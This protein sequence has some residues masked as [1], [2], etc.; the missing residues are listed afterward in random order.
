MAG[1]VKIIS[2]ADWHQ[3]HVIK[4]VIKNVIIHEIPRIYPTLVLAK[5]INCVFVRYL[6]RNA[7]QNALGR[8][9][10][11][12]KALSPNHLR[13]W[14]SFESRTK[15]RYTSVTTISMS[16]KEETNLR[17]I[18][19]VH[20]AMN[21]GIQIRRLKQKKTNHSCFLD[22]SSLTSTR[23]VSSTEFFFSPSN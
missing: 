2:R 21:I 17:A 13:P 7:L 6:C 10:T 20:V 23:Y 4:N 15:S 18:I 12:H 16:T 5:I 8:M 9:T 14:Q 3:V 1:L 11:F 19:H 22:K